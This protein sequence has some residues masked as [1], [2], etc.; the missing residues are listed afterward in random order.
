VVAE[1]GFSATGF[2]FILGIVAAYH[3][4]YGPYVA[5][6]SRYLPADT[7]HAATFWWT[8]AGLALGGIWVLGL[9]AALQIGYSQL[10]IVGAL[11]AAGDSGGAWLRVLVLLVLILGLINIGALNIYGAAISSLTIATSFLR[12]RPTRNL[13]IGFM[14][15]VGA[16]GTVGA[17][18][19]SGDLITSYE[20]FIFFLITFL[21]P[22]SAINL[23]DFYLVSHGRYDVEALS[24]PDGR[25]G[26]FNGPGL[27]AYVVGC[28]AL[29]PF[30]ST[31]YWSG[32]IAQELG[33]D[34][35]WLVGLV[36]PAALYV[37]GC[38]VWRSAPSVEPATPRPANA[39]D[40]V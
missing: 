9:G 6:Y 33:F 30:V 3:I 27:I 14:V 26:A 28:L 25:Y 37:I 22:W 21:V 1:H 23:A 19:L 32:P 10:P 20:N 34:L 15:T 8:Y 39:L 16:L 13:R 36:V 5:D 29:A 18:L 4:T 35:S 11:A 12:V 17:S 31:T 40:P 7:S 38:R 24:D 2:F